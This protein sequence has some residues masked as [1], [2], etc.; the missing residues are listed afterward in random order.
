MSS[1]PDILVVCMKSGL[2]LALEG[3]LARQ[4]DRAMARDLVRKQGV[5]ARFTG[6]CCPGCSVLMAGLGSPCEYR[7]LRGP[8]FV[9][10]PGGADVQ[11]AP[12]TP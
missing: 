9:P 5:D 11:P 3:V 8:L 4:E 6:G 7:P 2:V 1:E 12:P 10:R